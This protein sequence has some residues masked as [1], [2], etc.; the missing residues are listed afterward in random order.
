PFSWQCNVY[1]IP[2]T[3]YQI[4]L[5]KYVCAYTVDRNGGLPDLGTNPDCK[6]GEGFPFTLT[7]NGTTGSAYTTDANGQLSWTGV[8]AG[9]WTLTEGVVSGYDAPKVYCGAPQSAE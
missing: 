4:D 2:T 7:A 9:P 3:G 1:D 6:P 8:E 5:Y